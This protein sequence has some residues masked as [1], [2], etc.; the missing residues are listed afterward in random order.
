MDRN[1]LG[2][3]LFIVEGH[4]VHGFP[5][6]FGYAGAFGLAPRRLLRA[7]P[8]GVGGH[9]DAD[10]IM[11]SVIPTFHLDDVRLPRGRPGRPQRQH[12][13]LGAGIGKP[14]AFDGF[15]PTAHDFS[16]G[17]LV[18]VESPPGSSLSNLAAHS[19]LD[20]TETM[21]VNQRGC[22]V[23]EVKQTVAVHIHQFRARSPFNYEGIG[24]EIG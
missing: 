11:R 18:L 23:H 14:D 20:R 3:G 9:T 1:D 4:H 2:Q 10:G 6:I 21:A 22:V 13:G 7:R 16:Q 17:N 5:C 24:P 19:L 15:N 8:A 12:G